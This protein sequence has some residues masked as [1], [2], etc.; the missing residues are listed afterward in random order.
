MTKMQS[1]W[2]TP[3]KRGT[4]PDGSDGPLLRSQVISIPNGLTYGKDGH[5]PCDHIAEFEYALATWTMQ[6]DKT[7]SAMK[8]K[9]RAH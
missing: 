3:L 5:V 1:G 6:V 9:R 4:V 8:W 2:A 7:S